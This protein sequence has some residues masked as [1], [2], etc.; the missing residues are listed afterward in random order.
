MTK[1]PR[2]TVGGLSVSRMI[3]G[4]NWF[5]GFSHQ[6]PARDT[7]IK[8]NILDR[9]VI[10]DIL[11][12]F[13]RSGVDT[14]MGIL[15]DFPVLIDAIKE[16]EDRT[17]VHCIKIDTPIIN[18]ADTDSGRAEAEALIDQ[19]AK[20]GVEICMPH[21]VSVEQ[22]IDKGDKKIRRLDDYTKMIRERGMIPGLSA[23]MPEV[24]LYAD[25][26]N[27]DV[28]TY[29]Q[30]YNAAGF[31]MQV[32]IDWINNVIW[33]AKKPVMTIKPM[34]AGRVPPF[35]AFNFV[36]NTIREQDM[37]TVGTMSPQEA[38]EVIEL[39]MAILNK[40]RPEVAVR[41]TPAKGNLATEK[42]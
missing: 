11:E 20:L 31:L 33:N 3:I 6:T 10:A 13:F 8:E 37:V 40:R 26:N 23:H 14:I 21:H 2:T 7:Y 12:V 16:A 24:L 42:D 29:I 15:A 35:V 38:A 28:E 18:I 27:N 36:W 19:A 34:A 4:T 30:I 39:S 25:A 9:K 1:F 22:L 32:E 17:G 5:C 41:G